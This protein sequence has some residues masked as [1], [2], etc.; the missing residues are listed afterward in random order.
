MHNEIGYTPETEFTEEAP[1]PMDLSFVVPE[2][3]IIIHEGY[4]LQVID[5][6]VVM[7]KV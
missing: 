5:D 1:A 2:A 4:T 3:D 6:C 7:V